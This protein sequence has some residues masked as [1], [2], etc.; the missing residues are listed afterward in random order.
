MIST[1]LLEQKINQLIDSGNLTELQ[2]TQLLAAA[3]SLEDSSLVANTFSDLP[4]IENNLGRLFYVTDEDKFY[5]SNGEEWTDNFDTT[6]VL[7]FYMI[8]WGNNNDGRLGNNTTI[9]RSSPVTVLGGITN[10]NQVSAGGAHSLGLTDDG[11]AYAWGYNGNGQLGNHFLSVPRSSPVTVIGGITNWR[12][13]SAGNVHS[14]GVTD[15]G[16]AYAWGGG[17]QGRLGT[18]NTLAR[19]SPVSVVGGITNWRQVSAGEQHSLGVTDDGIAY[20]WGNDGNGR[21]GIGGTLARSSPVSVVGGITNWNQVSAGGA[22][23][24]GL[25]DDG[26]AYAWGSGSSGRLGDDTTDNKSSPV[27]VIG[28]ITN[29]SQVSAGGAHSLGLTDDGIAYAWGENFTAG[30]LGDNTRVRRSSPVTA[31]GGIDNWSQVSGGTQH[32]LG[33]AARIVKGFNEPL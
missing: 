10:W 23:S 29:W 26:I 15:D 24:L 17:F 11:I 13:V 7:D 21:L 20:A 8:S 2:V 3:Q 4:D 22:H 19:S 32:S 25:T 31:V 27:T 1:K 18:G 16:I 12:Q 6:A 5:F 14:L 9:N 28:G 30:E 33:V